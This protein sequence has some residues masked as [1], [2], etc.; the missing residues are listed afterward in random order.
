M[1]SRGGGEIGVEWSLS[2]VLVRTAMSASS[3]RSISA[4]SV[5]CLTADLQLSNTQFTE[6]DLLFFWLVT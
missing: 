4:I 5:A 6:G 3:E 2:Q 1:S